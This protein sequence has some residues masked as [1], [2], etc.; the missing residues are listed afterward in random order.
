GWFFFFF[1]LAVALISCVELYLLALKKG[2]N[3]NLT[4][5]LLAVVYLLYA[6]FNYIFDLYSFLIILMLLLGLVELFRKDGS[7]I[8]NIGATL[9]GI[10]YLGIFSSSLI[11]IREF[12]PRIDDIYRQGGLLIITIF[13][14]IW[15]CDSATYYIGTAFG[16]H[17]LFPR[18]SP[19]KSWEGAIAGFVFAIITF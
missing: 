14:A 10:F 8:Y 17:K 7:A 19:K 12:Y 11:G 13:A 2:M 3:A 6:R 16:K 9:L 1:V 15:I 18:V 4:I 5:G